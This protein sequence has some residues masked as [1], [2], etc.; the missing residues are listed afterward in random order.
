MR[1]ER[2]WLLLVLYIVHIYIYI[3][4]PHLIY[5]KHAIDEWSINESEKEENRFVHVVDVQGGKLIFAC[6]WRTRKKTDLCMLLTYK[7]EK[8]QIFAC[9][10]FTES[11][12]L[13]TLASITWSRRTRHISQGG[14]QGHCD[15]SILSITTTE[16]AAQ[17]P[18]T[19]Q[20]K[21][22]DYQA[23]STEVD[24]LVRGQG[25]IWRIGISAR[26]SG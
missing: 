4:N 25:C 15:W 6:Y 22:S 7:G 9:Y 5:L 8:N 18:W 26:V 20:C 19:R 3:M 24:G 17:S 16:T 10:W 12:V 14:V 11:Y 23:A 1:R 21:I 13:R 2:I